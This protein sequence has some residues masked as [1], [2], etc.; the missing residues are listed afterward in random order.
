MNKEVFNFLAMFLLILAGMVSLLY[1]KLLALLLFGIVIIKFINFIKRV[2]EIY[3]PV[4]QKKEL[5]KQI[6]LLKSQL[7]TAKEGKDNLLY[8]IKSLEQRLEELNYEI[9]ESWKDSDHH[10]P[11]SRSPGF[12]I[13]IIL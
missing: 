3:N 2:E 12:F 7:L 9:K 5:M 1:S 4:E 13:I 8:E 10:L 11:K 6:N